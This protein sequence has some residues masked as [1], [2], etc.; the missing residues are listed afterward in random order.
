MLYFWYNH[1]QWRY[2]EMS[3]K[4]F[5]KCEIIWNYNEDY[6]VFKLFPLFMENAE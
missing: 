2:K 4:Y 6:Q 1:T 3:V 5:Q